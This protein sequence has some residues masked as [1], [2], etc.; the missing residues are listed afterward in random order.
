MTTVKPRDNE[1][2]MRVCIDA[3]DEDEVFTAL[4]RTDYHWN[5]WL[6]PRFD[7]EQ[8]ERVAKMVGDNDDPNNPDG[9]SVRWEGDTVIF[10]F[11]SYADEEG[12]EG[13]R[14]APDADGMYDIGS[15]SWTW[16]EAPE[17]GYDYEEGERE[18]EIRIA[19]HNAV[20]R[21]LI[22]LNVPPFD[23]IKV[24]YLAADAAV[25]AYQKVRQ[26]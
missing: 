1:Q 4:V 12:Y 11:R 6:C 10:F 20:N 14:Y 3:T 7:R 21:A 16:S 2:L 15:M 19:T 8:A 23:R 26:Q 18:A 9:V 22:E 24:G 5:G 25:E 17:E 13:E